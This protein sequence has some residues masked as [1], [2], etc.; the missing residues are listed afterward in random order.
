MIKIIARNLLRTL[1]EWRHPHRMWIRLKIIWAYLGMTKRKRPIRKVGKIVVFYRICEKGYPKVKPNYIT[2][3]NC[4]RNAVKEFPL[5]VCEWKILADKLS[6]DTYQMLLKYV[7]QECVE[8]VS[9]GHGAGTFRIA[10]QKALDQY[11]DDDLIY[12]L[13]DDYLHL[14]G[15][16]NALKVAAEYN[17]G[18]YLTLYD[19][20]DMY[21]YGKY[22]NPYVRNGGECTTVFWSGNWHWKFT[23]STTMTLASFVNTLRRDKKIFWRWTAET[24]PHDFELFVDLRSVRNARLICPIPSLSTHGDTAYHAF[25]TN[26]EEVV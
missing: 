5:G 20:P 15:A 6:D 26:W 4:L 25:G 1:H 14:P 17:L 18:D 22:V 19:H 16:L 21:G 7:P 10:Y 9:V 8:R 13:E 12:F 24:S 11:N 2:K 23:R 3:E